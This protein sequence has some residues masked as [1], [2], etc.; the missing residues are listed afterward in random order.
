MRWLAVE[1]KL[2]CSDS[3]D[4]MALTPA[5]RDDAANQWAKNAVAGNQPPL[6]V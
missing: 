1:W 2:E 6:I 4:A 3:V 5:Q